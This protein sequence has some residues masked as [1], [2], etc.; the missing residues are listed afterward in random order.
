MT[1]RPAV[2]GVFYEET[3]QELVESIEGCFLGNLGPGALPNANTT[4]I[5]RVVGLV[6]PHA[7]YIYSG[8]AAAYAY[9]E[10]AQDGLPDT[11]VILG[12]NH[13]GAGAAA[14]VSTGDEWITPL[15]TVK[16][17][18]NIAEE[19]LRRS[20]FARADNVAHSR[21]HS[22][23]VQL[24]FLQYIGGS[25]VKI[26]PIAV[27]YMNKSEAFM[28]V[29]DLGS[30]TARS[31]EG[32]SAVI[33]SSTDFSHYESRESARAKDAEAMR[34]IVNLDPEGLIE[35]V[36]ERSITMCGV[37]GTAIMLEACKAMGATCARQLTYYTSGDVTGDTDQVVGYGALSVLRSS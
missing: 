31:L 22:V 23:E 25:S 33:I 6:C 9:M 35:T 15:G 34:H 8:S 19:I 11:A 21:E 28:L 3:K 18:T 17:D 13:H 7:G 12:P 37:V 4:R 2:A 30:A 10:L 16:V 32:K 29:K 26:V 5:G 36:Y 27:A 20:N 14:A 1:R 24:P